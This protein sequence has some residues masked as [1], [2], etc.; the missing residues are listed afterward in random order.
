MSWISPSP[1]NRGV[2]SKV[3]KSRDRIVVLSRNEG[4]VIRTK[5]IAL[6]ITL[7]VTLATASSDPHKEK[8]KGTGFGKLGKAGATACKSTAKAGAVAGKETAKG[9]KIAGKETVRGGK[10]AGKQTGKAGTTPGQATAHG[11]AI[12]GRNTAEA[13]SAG[14]DSEYQSAP[15]LS[16]A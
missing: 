9:G 8:K 10:V 5:T 7:F 16:K 13:F 2:A 4:N 12:A 14:P 6:I 11:G 1:A 3:R 15:M